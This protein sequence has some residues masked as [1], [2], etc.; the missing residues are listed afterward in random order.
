[1]VNGEYEVDKNKKNIYFL[2]MSG[3]VNCEIGSRNS[4]YNGECF[5][6]KDGEFFF[7]YGEFEMRREVQSVVSKI[8]FVFRFQ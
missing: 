7:K 4:N 5:W 8:E 3:Q 6:R 2:S 1:M